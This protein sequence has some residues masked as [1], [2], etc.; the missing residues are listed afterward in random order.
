MYEKVKE[1]SACNDLT[2]D[3]PSILISIGKISLFS[4]TRMKRSLTSHYGEKKLTSHYG[5]NNVLFVLF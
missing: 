2:D 1:S 4:H 5:E 3:H